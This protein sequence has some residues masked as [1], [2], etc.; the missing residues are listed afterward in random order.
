MLLSLP[1]GMQGVKNL[2]ASFKRHNVRVL[3]PFSPWDVGTDNSAYPVSDAVGGLSRDFID[4][5][6]KTDSDG[7]NGD[8]MDQ[9]GSGWVTESMKRG[10]ELVTE[11]ERA[12]DIERQLPFM[13]L[14]STPLLLSSPL[15]LTPS[16]TL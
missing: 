6:V 1:G 12:N 5:L 11:S 7:F 13:K 10:H 14:R 2:V 4:I 15:P 16:L 3:W 9:I 8:T